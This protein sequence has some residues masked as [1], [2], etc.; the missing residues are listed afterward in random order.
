M[1][2]RSYGTGAGLG[3]ALMAAHYRED[4]V[5]NGLHVLCGSERKFSA[6]GLAMI[7]AVTGWQ[8]ILIAVC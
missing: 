6:G 1:L 7:V 4:F 5:F 8:P 2:R 3:A